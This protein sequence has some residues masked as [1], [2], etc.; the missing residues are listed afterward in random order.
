MITNAIAKRYAKALVQLASE[1]GALEKYQQELAGFESI[2]GGA[3]ELKAALAS[4]A[5]NMESKQ[6]ILGDLLEKAAPSE[7]VGKFLRLL[8]ERNRISLLPQIVSSYGVL[9]D[10][11]SG[12][13]RPVLTTA[14]PLD[15]SQVGQIR[16]GLEQ[17]TGKKV[18]LDVVTDPSLI[19]GV[20]TQ[21]GD[22]VYDGSV[23]TQ[24][25][26]IHDILQKG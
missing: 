26:R 22:K 18:V 1:E 3:P 17:S 13:V 21:I 19:G 8:L 4:P 11:I 14:I 15:E 16:G 24:L 5:C 2:I 6:A 25:S 12:V 10:R 9:A 7:T 23:R 20:I